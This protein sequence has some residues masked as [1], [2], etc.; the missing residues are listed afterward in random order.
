[1]W[2]CERGFELDFRDSPDLA[3]CVQEQIGFDELKLNSISMQTCH[4]GQTLRYFKCVDCF[5]VMSS[6]ELPLKQFLGSTW[7]WKTDCSWQCLY[8]QGFT[9]LKAEDGLYW[10]CEPTTRMQLILEGAD[11]TWMDPGR[12][13]LAISTEEQQAKPVVGDSERLLLALVVLAAVIVLILKCILVIHCFF[14]CRNR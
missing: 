10:E 5:D 12:A 14:V 1:M 7:E 8:Q 6:T 3:Q 4:P 13:L 9:A 11:D 2:E